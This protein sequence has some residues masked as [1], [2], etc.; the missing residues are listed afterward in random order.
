VSTRGSAPGKGRGISA[1]HRRALGVALCRVDEFLCLVEEWVHGRAWSGELYRETN[2]LSADQGESLLRLSGEVRREI[3]EARERLGLEPS[4]VDAA[5]DIWAR[6]A[7]LRE[8]VSGID[9][10]HMA[11]YGPLSPEDASYLDALSGRLVHA[12]DALADAVK[13]GVRR[14]E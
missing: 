4:S 11:A 2:T 3:R 5:A 1:N 9:T 13:R 8:T 14:A 6:C 12:L 10:A 7:A